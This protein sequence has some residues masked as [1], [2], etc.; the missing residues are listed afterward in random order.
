MHKIVSLKFIK[1]T[2][3]SISSIDTLVLKEKCTNTLAH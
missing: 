3:H 1:K 2:F